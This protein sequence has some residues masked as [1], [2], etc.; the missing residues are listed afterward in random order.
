MIH[1]SK[2]ESDS[3]FTH[4]LCTISVRFLQLHGSKSCKTRGGIDGAAILGYHL[5]GPFISASK[6]GAH[7]EHFLLPLTNG[8][9]D[10]EDVYGSN[11][12]N[13]AIVTLAPELPGA[14]DVIDW[15][16]KK[17]VVVSVG[18]W[19]RFFGS[20]GNENWHCTVR[21]FVLPH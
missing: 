4:F 6:R 2:F 14:I 17:G 20:F 7:P 11:L 13:V 3:C 18:E 1:E 12:E 19:F 16:V 8:R 15:L 21:K 10:A 9:K 5:E